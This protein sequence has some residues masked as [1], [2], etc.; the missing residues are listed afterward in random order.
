M[1]KLVTPP[2]EFA[3]RMQEARQRAGMRLDEASVEARRV[4]GGEYGPSRETIRRYEAGLISEDRADPLIVIA[5]AEVY[6]VSVGQLSWVI[7]RQSQTISKV[8]SRHLRREGITE[9]KEE[10][11]AEE[12]E[13]EA[14]GGRKARTRT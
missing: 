1:P 12:A 4:I 8:L 2:T 11:E 14:A 6:G 10:T 9:L 3:R 13:V 5:L 7:A